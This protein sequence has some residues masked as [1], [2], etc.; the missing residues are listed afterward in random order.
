MKL[1]KKLYIIFCAL[2]II[3]VLFIVMICTTKNNYE[4]IMIKS[5][6]IQ[7]GMNKKEVENLLGSPMNINSSH[8][9]MWQ[10]N[11]VGQ[12]E[13]KKFKFQ[14]IDMNSHLGVFVL[15]NNGI[16]ITDRVMKCTEASPIE[17]MAEHLQMYD[18]SKILKILEED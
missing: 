17:I 10:F 12:Y 6:K 7:L 5:S 13:N 3:S 2:T 18:K 16:L 11:D 9:W 1:P 14:D 4:R 8:V 15:F